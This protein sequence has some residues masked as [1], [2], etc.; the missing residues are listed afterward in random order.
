MSTVNVNPWVSRNGIQRHSA[1]KASPVVNPLPLS[2]GM[3]RA[4]RQPGPQQ[5]HPAPRAEC[6]QA[7]R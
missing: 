6:P 3:D 5:Q 2:E 7:S 1:S 4:E